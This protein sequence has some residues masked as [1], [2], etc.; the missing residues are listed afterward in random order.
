MPHR[1]NGGEYRRGGKNLLGH[2]HYY[3]E[4]GQSRGTRWGA[5]NGQWKRQRFLMLCQCVEMGAGGVSLLRRVIRG[6]RAG[7]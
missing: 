4:G 7:V 2:P 5:K 6:I 1:L 3:G